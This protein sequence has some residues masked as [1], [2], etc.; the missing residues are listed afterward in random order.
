MA[1]QRSARDVSAARPI[2]VEPFV[3]YPVQAAFREAAAT[4]VYLR[5]TA[6]GKGPTNALKG[7]GSC[8]PMA[9]LAA[10]RAVAPPS[11]ET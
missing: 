7:L 6:A 4:K 11:E 2:K 10:A 3:P 8:R 5:L 9:E 1:A